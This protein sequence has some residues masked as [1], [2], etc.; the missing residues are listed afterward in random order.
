M[1]VKASQ[2][3]GDFY[4]CFKDYGCVR[5][6]IS[7]IVLFVWSLSSHSRIIH[8]FG[9]VIIAAVGLQIL[10]CDRYSWPMSSEGHSYSSEGSAE[11]HIY[12]V[13][14]HPFIMFDS[15]TQPSA[16]EANALTNCG[17]A[18][19]DNAFDIFNGF[20][21]T[22]YASNWVLYLSKLIWC[23]FFF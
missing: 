3:L 8:S 18:A 5:F 7:Y 23:F 4:V 9:D 14:G 16:C 17:I 12:C 21:K 2:W 11:C 13:T 22:T 15:N 1:E 19:V 10:N 6:H 20:S